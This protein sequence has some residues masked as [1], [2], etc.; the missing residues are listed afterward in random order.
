MFVLYL[1]VPDLFG[2]PSTFQAHTI[3]LSFWIGTP[4]LCT[5]FFD[6][7]HPVAPLSINVFAPMI[8]PS[9]FQIEIGRWIELVLD[10]EI[11]TKAIVKKE[12]GV[13][14]SPPFQKTYDDQ[15]VKCGA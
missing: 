13:G 3:W 7:K 14:P 6:M 11:N 9:S 2:V 8:L 5:F 1:T 12:D 4:S 15:R 10:P